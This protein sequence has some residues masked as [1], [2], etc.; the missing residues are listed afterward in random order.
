MSVDVEWLVKSRTTRRVGATHFHVG[1]RMGVKAQPLHRC[2]LSAVCSHWLSSRDGGS[3]CFGV[4]QS[5]HSTIAACCHS[6]ESLRERALLASF[7]ATKRDPKQVLY[8]TFRVG[9]DCIPLSTVCTE[10]F[11][12]GDLRGN[13]IETFHLILFD[14]YFRDVVQ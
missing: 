1:A 2:D 4:Y 10:P 12:P 13:W 7:E 3:W 8:V 11:L 9:C 5:M 6:G 14:D